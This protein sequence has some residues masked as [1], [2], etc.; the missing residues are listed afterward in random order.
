M[1]GKTREIEKE[2]S[3]FMLLAVANEVGERSGYREERTE[4]TRERQRE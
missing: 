2:G 1:V 4:D 3:S